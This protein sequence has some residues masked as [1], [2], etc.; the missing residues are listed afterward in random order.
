MLSLITTSLTKTALIWI[1]FVPPLDLTLKK[2][3]KAPLISG[4][5][6]V[7]FTEMVF[8]WFLSKKIE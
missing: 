4:G 7:T 6:L 8:P 5:F 1:F 3:V 2:P